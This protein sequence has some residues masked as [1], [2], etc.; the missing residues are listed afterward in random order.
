MS[1]FEYD[2][3]TFVVESFRPDPVTI[4]VDLTGTHTRIRDLA[5]GE[6]LSAVTGTPTPASTAPGDTP[7]FHF[8]I[9][10]PPHTY[11]AFA[12]Q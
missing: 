8:Q 12:V 3:G 7:R 10:V 9:R 11:R 2:N 4:D 6:T 1:L 5:S